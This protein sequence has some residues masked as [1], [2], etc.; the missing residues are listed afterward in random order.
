VINPRIQANPDTISDPPGTELFDIK[1]RTR[2]TSRARWRLGGN[3]APRG[4]ADEASTDLNLDGAH[5][6]DER[7]APIFML[8]QARRSA[9]RKR[10]LRLLN[11][12]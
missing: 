12:D 3:V 5:G 1:P 10:T 6:C 2:L 7:R 9:P 4:T 8:F 11:G